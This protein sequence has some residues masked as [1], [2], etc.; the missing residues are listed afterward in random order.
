MDIKNIFKH[1]KKV[2]KYDF[3]KNYVKSKTTQGFLENEKIA[4]IFDRRE[5]KAELNQAL[6]KKSEGGLTK[7]EM[8]EVIGELKTLTEKERYE[9]AKAVF[10]SVPSGERFIR[11]KENMRSGPTAKQ[12]ANSSAKNNPAPAGNTQMT[13]NK[14]AR[15]INR[16]RAA[17]P[18]SSGNKEGEQSKSS[19]SRAMEATMR[20]KQG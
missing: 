15:I 1:G 11:P 2:S 17:S 9:F 16:A 20:N 3:R 13:P 19:F 14:M 5:E 7:T 8:K 6:N 12:A 10:P 4:E 18:N